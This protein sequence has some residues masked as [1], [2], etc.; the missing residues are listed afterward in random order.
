M[1]VFAPSSTVQEAKSRFASALTSG[2]DTLVRLGHGRE[3]A[4]K[5]VLS[6]IA[7]GCSADEEEVRRFVST[8]ARRLLIDL[9]CPACYFQS[10]LINPSNHIALPRINS[11]YS[12]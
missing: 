1:E 8:A 9:D 12:N 6:E 3:R 2:V 7:G 10:L 5:Q 11:R 4:A